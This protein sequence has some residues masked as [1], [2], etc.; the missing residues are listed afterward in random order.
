M[1]NPCVINKANTP[2][3]HNS[4]FVHG[5]RSKG[6]SDQ[7]RRKV[8]NT[9]Q[10]FILKAEQKVVQ[11]VEIGLIMRLIQSCGDITQ[12]KRRN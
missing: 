11:F 3:M 7:K 4:I 1:V 10:I 2:N 6:I 8:L 5:I 9:E 12:K